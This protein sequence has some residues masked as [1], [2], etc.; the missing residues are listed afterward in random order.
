MYY[1]IYISVSVGPGG[2]G[3][4]VVPGGGTG[5]AG[6]GVVDED[7][8]GAVQP[9]QPASAQGEEKK[10]EGEAQGNTC[11]STV[12]VHYA[13]GFQPFLT[14][15]CSLQSYISIGIHLVPIEI[16]NLFRNPPQ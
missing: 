12:G 1:K 10:S 2:A 16:I 4:G 7:A 8:S 6:P 15:M 11:S 5:G 14:S 3:P 9:E 13:S